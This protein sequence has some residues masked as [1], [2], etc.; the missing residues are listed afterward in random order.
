M[1]GLRR[2]SRPSEAVSQS[3][4][5]LVRGA[6]V[7]TIVL[8]RRRIERVAALGDGVGDIADTDR[9]ARIV[10]AAAGHRRHRPARPVDDVGYKFGAWVDTAWWQLRLGD[11]DPDS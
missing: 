4:L 8:F 5:H 7:P 2:A 11:E 9:H 10:E 3:Q 6:D 1:T